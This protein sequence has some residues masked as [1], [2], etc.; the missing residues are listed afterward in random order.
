MSTPPN[1]L[2]DR[3]RSSAERGVQAG[4][5]SIGV[6]P[7]LAKKIAPR[8]LK[9]LI[10]V[11]T[12]LLLLPLLGI[13]AVISTVVGSGDA[14][15]VETETAEKF[16]SANYLDAY[17]RAGEENQI[18]WTLLAA[19]GARA[20]YHG[21]INPYEQEVP[22]FLLVPPPP[23]G[24]V[25]SVLYIG[26]SLAVGSSGALTAA[27]DATG[28]PVVANVVIGENVA[29][30]A[31]QLKDAV[32]NENGLSLLANQDV[33]IDLG[34]NGTGG[35]SSTAAIN[36]VLSQVSTT[37][38]V[39]WVNLAHAGGGRF[40]DALDKARTTWP[41]LIVLDWAGYSATEGI[42]PSEDG[43][44]YSAAGYTARGNFIASALSSGVTASTGAA[45]SGP[46]VMTLS[47]SECPRPERDIRGERPA[48]A[49][50]P[51]LLLPDQLARFGI[52][53]TDPQ[54]IC[55]AAIALAERLSQVRDEL[56]EERDLDL[57]DLVEAAQ[58]GSPE[59]AQVI[60]RFW[61]EVVDRAG[62]LGS[63]QIVAC[64]APAQNDLSD[65]EWVAATIEDVWEC[66]TAGLGLSLVASAQD[67]GGVWTYQNVDTSVSPRLYIQEAIGV[68]WGF[69][70]WGQAAC[71]TADPGPQGVFPLR[72]ATFAE[73]AE[74]DDEGGL[75][76]NRCD[77][78]A[79][80]RAA[81]R[82]FAAAE[83]LPPA[84]RPT[85]EGP[86]QPLQGGW[87]AMPLALGASSVRASFA[88][89]GPWRDP[90]NIESCTAAAS[91]FLLTSPDNPNNPLRG[92]TL[93][94]IGAIISEQG[95]ADLLVQLDA[96]LDA[97]ATTIAQTCT[98]PRL[99]RL[100]GWALLRQVSTGEGLISSG[101]AVSGATAALSDPALAGD[102]IAALTARIR[103]GAAANSSLEVTAGITPLVN[104]LS[105]APLSLAVPYRSPRNRSGIT[106]FEL[107]STAYLYGGLFKGAQ[108]A[109][110]NG[111]GLV[112]STIPF[113][114]VFNLVGQKFQ[115]D[116]RLLAAIAYQES[117]FNVAARCDDL[118][119]TG[120]AGY[121]MM[122]EDASLAERAVR[123]ELCGLVASDPDAAATIQVE[124]AAAKFKSFLDAVDG[125]AEGALL[126]YNSG[127]DLGR[128]WTR[129]RPDVEVLRAE[130]RRY[131]CER[132]PNDWADQARDGLRGCEWRGDVTAQYVNPLPGVRSAL[133]KYR[134][135]QLLFPA[136]VLSLVQTLIGPD[137]CPLA[138][139]AT[140]LPGKTV[141]RNANVDYYELCVRSVAQAP[142]P[143]A[144]MAI[145]WA[146]A[147][148]GSPY[149]QPQR[150]GPS[151]FDCS[152]LVMRAYRDG[153][154]LPVPIATTHSLVPWGGRTRP[155]WSVPLPV[156]E[157]RPGDLYFPS[158]GNVLDSAGQPGGHVV[159][160]LADGLMIHA[161][162]TGDVVHVRPV[163][164]NDG[165]EPQ[166]RR[167]DPNL[168][169]LTGS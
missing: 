20:S 69:S 55:D 89:N 122:Q 127:V 15:N 51:L 159:M 37:T 116:P 146:M 78:E 47:D 141:T 132:R 166:V 8:V 154:G 71:D 80:I 86:Y 120:T 19:V 112:G 140:Q 40:N 23:G 158:Y 100:A 16:V 105:P 64:E 167:V 74:R 84:Q 60:Q 144:A 83:A 33:I 2:R 128:Y 13:A 35:P 95:D 58:E 162:A 111:F 49:V 32:R 97:G 119:Y 138:P 73:Y 36:L 98:T 30:G 29:W 1:P 129:V 153:G 164:V 27:L 104:R 148:A 117:N 70:E 88:E 155:A 25:S 161:P 107:V 106:G 12:V 81:A 63:A 82:A 21:R 56:L 57:N 165:I 9:I 156:Y 99:S 18:P 87:A 149:S 93:G 91:T 3:A 125:D 6:P 160:L 163:Y 66:E 121:G 102:Q 61:A 34:T 54:N 150:L 11:L 151:T 24:P 28:I 113:A 75:V 65:Q 79:N 85:A 133:N 143:E 26:D 48:Q 142:T 43:V 17:V 115:I 103:S 90:R 41:N 118:D 45:L 139:P 101:A 124:K 44:H 77:P 169:R 76:A 67:V 38:R 50:G 123:V 136:A 126:A 108:L 114:E 72:A 31:E 42:T 131:W 152:S 62:V 14:W 130:A 92:R 68:A 52:T 145:K 168:A 22:S 96:Y 53:M 137:G 147:R 39:Y 109:A 134:E 46:G 10:P 4:L 135:Y 110:A 5:A 94:E 7:A 157:G 59:A